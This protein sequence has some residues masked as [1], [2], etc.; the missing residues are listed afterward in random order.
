MNEG[1]E[2]AVC[3][4]PTAKPLENR[5]KAKAADNNDN[6]RNKFVDEEKG[7]MFAAQLEDWPPP[8]D[9]KELA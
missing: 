5:N 3:F 7:R 8:V 6:W 9:R 4:Q 1:G 2:K